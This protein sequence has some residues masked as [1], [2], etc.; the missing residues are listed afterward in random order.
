MYR[1]LNEG[2]FLRLHWNP[3]FFLKL[4]KIFLSCNPTE[5]PKTP[6]SSLELHW[7]SHQA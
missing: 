7:K 2:F 3:G 1:I 4:Q 5:T 6:H